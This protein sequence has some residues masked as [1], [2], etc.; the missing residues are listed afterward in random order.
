MNS[1]FLSSILQANHTIKTTI[2]GETILMTCANMVLVE[3]LHSTWLPMIEFSNIETINTRYETL[4]FNNWKVIGKVDVFYKLYEYFMNVIYLTWNIPFKVILIKQCSYTIDMNDL[5]IILHSMDLMNENEELKEPEKANSLVFYSKLQLN[6]NTSGDR[7]YGK[8]ITSM[9][10]KSSIHTIALKSLN[11]KFIYD[12]NERSPYAPLFMD[13]M[14]IDKEALCKNVEILLEY[15]RDNEN[16]CVVEDVQNEL[17]NQNRRNKTSQ[18]VYYTNNNLPRY[19]DPSRE[20]DMYYHTQLS[21]RNMNIKMSA[22]YEDVEL[23]YEILFQASQ[24]FMEAIHYLSTL[25]TELDEQP[26]Q[27][28]MSTDLCLFP[29]SQCISS[30]HV[31]HKNNEELKYD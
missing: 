8:G 7:F 24:S 30:F 4:T 23:I 19:A 18:D 3:P 10:L 9:T 12:P 27:E 1:F 15:Q 13:L 6:Y 25:N 20:V 28:P 14:E 5:I 21:L 17:F 22:C 16:K 26:I 29:S 31:E 11:K 2:V